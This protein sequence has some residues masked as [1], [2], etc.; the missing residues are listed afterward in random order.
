MS[1]PL[2]PFVL[3]AGALMMRIWHRTGHSNSADEF[4]I[5]FDEIG[6]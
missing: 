6:P 5:G 4:G 3:A 2:N 1:L